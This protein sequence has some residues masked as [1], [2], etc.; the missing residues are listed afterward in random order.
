[1]LLQNASVN[2]HASQKLIINLLGKAK[3]VLVVII[4]TQR[5]AL[6]IHLILLD[7]KILF[8]VCHVQMDSLQRKRLQGDGID[9]MDEQN[10]PLEI[11][12]IQTCR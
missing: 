4:R 11:H 6:E 8:D 12:E 10:I 2:Y 1:M 9:V 3:S 7:C 5:K